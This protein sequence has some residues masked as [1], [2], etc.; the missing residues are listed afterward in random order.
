MI[1]EQAD[2]L[3]NPAFWVSQLRYQS[4][5]VGPSTERLTVISIIGKGGVG[6]EVSIQ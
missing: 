4:V 5:V 1:F 6:S 2:V 3:L